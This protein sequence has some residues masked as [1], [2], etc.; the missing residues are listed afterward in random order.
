[1]LP[2]IY[3]DF[4][5]M[6]TDDQE[7]VYIDRVDQERHDVLPFLHPGAVVTLFDEELEVTATIELVRFRPDYG[8]WLGRPD[9]STSSDRAP[10]TVM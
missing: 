9:W 7:R 10:D 2:R 1:V 8:A 3:V 5:T 4:N 6:N